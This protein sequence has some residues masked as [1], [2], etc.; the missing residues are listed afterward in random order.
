MSI[1]FAPSTDISSLVSL[2]LVADDAP[3][4]MLEECSSQAVMNG[5]IAI[6]CGCDQ[7]LCLTHYEREKPRWFP[8]DHIWCYTCRPM[9]L[10]NSGRFVRWEK[11]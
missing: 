10:G 1:G 7:P 5:V 8:G 3:V 4:C 2:D 11:I 6:S 9:A